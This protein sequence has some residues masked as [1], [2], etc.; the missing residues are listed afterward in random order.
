MFAIEL[1]LNQSLGIEMF[2]Q[3]NADRINLYFFS[4]TSFLGLLFW[5]LQS[6]HLN[7]VFAS[8]L[9]PDKDLSTETSP[10]GDTS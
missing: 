5:G 6:A 7:F 1:T 2:P 4:K 8:E 10:H 3:G 9:A